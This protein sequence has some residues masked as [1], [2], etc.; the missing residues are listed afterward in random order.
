MKRIMQHKYAKIAYL[1][2]IIYAI[3]AHTYDNDSV[4]YRCEYT[5]L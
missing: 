5:E 1:I 2:K 4:M 3:I